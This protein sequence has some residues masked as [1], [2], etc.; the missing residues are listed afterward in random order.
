MRIPAISLPIS[1]FLNT[2]ARAARKQEDAQEKQDSAVYEACGDVDHADAA[3]APPIRKCEAEAFYKSA[4]YKQLYDKYPA[5]MSPQQIG[6]IYTEVFTPVGG[7]ARKNAKRV[8]IDVHGGGFLENARTESHL[9]SYQL[10][11]SQDQGDQHDYRQ[12][13]E[14]AFPSASED[15]AAVYR[16]LLKTYE[17][18]NIGIYGCS[19]GGLLTAE[20][21]AWLQK[22][23]LPSPGAVAM[24][25]E[26]AGYWTEGD[27]GYIGMEMIGGNI[28][29]KS[30]DN[31]YFKNTDPNDPLAFPIRS[32]SVMANFPPSLLVAATRDPALSSVVQ[33]HSVLVIRCGS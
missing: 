5:T 13:P 30:T 9:E 12:A 2:E 15:V 4:G 26:G 20:S 6:G 22:E 18:K 24:L 33:T 10:R 31:P 29:G 19:A 32:P 25:C 7:I 1:S 3:H 21:V 16:E 28:W 14:F 11:R 8:L 23:H 17:P 27:T